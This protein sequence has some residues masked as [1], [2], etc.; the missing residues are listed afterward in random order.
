MQPFE[1]P[2]WWRNHHVSL[3]VSEVTLDGQLESGRKGN[4]EDCVGIFMGRTICISLVR[5]QSW[6]S[7]ELNRR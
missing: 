2:G 4:V 5:T 7:K 3:V 1:D 6:D